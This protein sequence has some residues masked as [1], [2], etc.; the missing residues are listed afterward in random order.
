M[1]RKEERDQ[2]KVDRRA[3]YT[4]S[5]RAI[6]LELLDI[7]DDMEDDNEKLRTELGMANGT[8]NL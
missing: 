2:L 4:G 6:V 3:I 5:G 7:I 8:T 1:T